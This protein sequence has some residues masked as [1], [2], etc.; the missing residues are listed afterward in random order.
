MM[1]NCQYILLLSE[2][3]LYL[4]HLKMGSMKLERNSIDKLCGN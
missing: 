3:L 1:L 2:Y 4:Y